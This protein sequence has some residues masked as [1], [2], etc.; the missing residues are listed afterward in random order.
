MRSLDSAHPEAAGA[1]GAFLE[2]VDEEAPGFVE[3]FY[4][5]GS[6]ALDDYRIGRSDI[7]F[8]AVSAER[9][10]TAGLAAL[11][12]GYAKHRSKHPRPFFDGIF[13]TW[14]ELA[15]GP[16]RLQGPRAIIRDTGFAFSTAGGAG[17]PVI[18]HTLAHHGVRCRGPALCDIELWTDPV[19]LSSWTLDN[20]DDYWRP[21]VERHRRLFSVRGMISLSPWFASWSVLGVSRL[22]Y[23]LATGEIT[24]KTGAGLYALRTFSR[25]WHPLIE[26]CLANRRGGQSLLRNPVR[27]RK[28]TLAFVCLVIAEAKLLFNKWT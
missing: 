4:L 1:V 11:E 20:L 10:D 25:R 6:T 2:A 9:P 14:D 18:W 12:R 24:S 23:T 7:D 13:I 15:H 5:S 16:D 28:E 19:R 8:V 27:R 22:H 21:W 3:G 17:N 26:E